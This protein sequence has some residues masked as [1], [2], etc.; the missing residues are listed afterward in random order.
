MLRSSFSVVDALWWTGLLTAALI[1]A[2]TVCRWLLPGLDELA[3]GGGLEVVLYGA[4]SV[5]LVRRDGEPRPATVALGLVR[6]PAWLLLVGLSLGVTLHGATELIQAGI[7]RLSPTPEA[8]IRARLERLTAGDS[9]ARARLA[10]FAVLLAPFAEEVFFRGALTRRLAPGRG[11][12]SVGLSTAVCFSVSHLEP[13][14]WASLLVV[15]LAL[16]ALR[17]ATP[18]IL[19]GYLLHA[20]F[21]ATTLSLVWLDDASLAFGA[22]AWSFWSVGTLASVVLLTV[23][24]RAARQEPAP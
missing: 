14:I 8:V 23:V 17:W 10:V 4:A 6:A 22:P 1:A 9:A 16:A 3:L 13:R 11:F 20:A 15:A 19:P 24:A 7:E 12:W 5:W 2:L 18:S 21:N